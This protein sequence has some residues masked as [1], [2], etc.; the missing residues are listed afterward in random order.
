MKKQQKQIDE[1]KEA[2]KRAK[3][4]QN[5]TSALFKAYTKEQVAKIIINQGFA[6][7]NADSVD[8]VMLHEDNKAFDIIAFRGYPE[9][10]Q[11]TV[12][13][14]SSKLLTN[15]VIKSGRPLYFHRGS[16]ILHPYKVAKSYMDKT[17]TVS[18]ALLP[19]II[20]GYVVG[21]LEFSFC[22]HQTF[23]KEN[24]NF[25]Q[26]L[27]NQCSLAFER[28]IALEKLKDSKEELEVILKNIADGIT[29]QD[30]MGKLIY[31]N[32]SA[33]EASGYKSEEEML[34]APILDYIKRFE[35]FDER[36]NNFPF[37]NLP[38]RRAID[39]ENPS[40]TLKF[41]ERK[42]GISRWINISSTAI[43]HI[44]G[45]P[46]LVVN[47]MHD[48]TRE[49]EIEQRKDDFISMASHELKTPITTIKA[50]S[51]L[52]KKKFANSESI[53][54]FEKMDDQLNTLTE[55]VNELLDITKIQQGR[56]GIHKNKFDL[57]VIIEDIIAAMQSITNH[58]IV[59]ENSSKVEVV[60]DKERIGQ[61]ITN[62]ISNAIKYSSDKEKIIVKL[63]KKENQ[64]IFSVQDFGIGIPVKEQEKVF[65][66]FYRA[67]D[68]QKTYPGLGL[69][70]YISSEIIKQHS[71]KIWVSSIFGKGATF[72]FSLPL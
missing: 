11:K 70:L 17:K 58:K 9:T 18:A 22:T 34:K 37:E 21:V 49:K 2:Y 52:L 62:F 55:L 59:F 4:L 54:L 10:F 33:V 6:I 45:T 39:E 19:L 26:T 72:Y 12:F 64:C 13:E 38:G 56:L 1:I 8:I 24:K 15:S 65:E 30:S 36:G 25:M 41:V 46:R 67:E 60:G 48:K 44:D 47:V 14:N 53:K 40:V 16:K 42:T 7:L 29:V 23:R 43:R 71:G 3:G 28:I 31:A 35:I 61:V 57:Q 66:R 69:G 63:T 27:A 51:Q 68:E 50:F 32:K 5:V 20:E